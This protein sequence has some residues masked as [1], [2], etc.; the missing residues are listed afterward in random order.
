MSLVDKRRRY[1]CAV[2]EAKGQKFFNYMDLEILSDRERIFH[3]LPPF[4]KGKNFLCREE[5]KK[6]LLTTLDMVV[7]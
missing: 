7:V 1:K 6:H 3:L 5:A 4:C 2:V